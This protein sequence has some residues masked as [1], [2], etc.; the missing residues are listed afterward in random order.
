M[1]QRIKRIVE[2][3]KKDP[4]ILDSILKEQID[5]LPEVGDGNAVFI[6]QGTEQEYEEFQQEEKGMKGWYKRLQNL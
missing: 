3:S 2:L 5:Q 1:F 4:I 6:S